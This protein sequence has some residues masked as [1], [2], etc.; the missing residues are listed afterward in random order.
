MKRRHYFVGDIIYENKSKTK[1]PVDILHLRNMHTH[2][3]IVSVWHET[4]NVRGFIRFE[5]RIFQAKNPLHLDRTQKQH[6]ENE[7]ISN[8]IRDI[9]RAHYIAVYFFYFFL[10]ELISLLLNTCIHSKPLHR[11][12][13]V[14][15]LRRRQLRQRRQQGSETFLCVVHM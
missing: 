13:A 9:S 15:Q 3:H 6:I 10:V 8:G 5:A 12:K 11:A 1:C 4:M 14:K 2:T 7:S